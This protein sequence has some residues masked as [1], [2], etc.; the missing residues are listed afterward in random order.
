MTT[1]LHP[2][3]HTYPS[4]LQWIAMGSPAPELLPDVLAMAF[5]VL[6]KIF[7]VNL[8]EWQIFAESNTDIHFFNIFRCQ[9]YG[10]KGYYCKVDPFCRSNDE[11][12]IL[13]AKCMCSSETVYYSEDMEEKISQ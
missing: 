5:V 2:H 1:V 13:N 7:P 11:Q 4:V 12:G 10:Q 6:K 3:D 9:K 8:C